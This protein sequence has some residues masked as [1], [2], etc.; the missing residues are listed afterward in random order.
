MKLVW[1]V[2]D[3]QVYSLCNAEGLMY[4]YFLKTTANLF[5]TFSFISILI[6]LPLNVYNSDFSSH[7]VFNSSLNNTIIN[8]TMNETS[9]HINVTEFA[10]KFL[11]RLTVKTSFDRSGTLVLVLFFSFVFT[12]LALYQIYR[13]GEKLHKINQ[14]NKVSYLYYISG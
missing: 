12:L 4:L 9:T 7:G 14:F 8:Q 3:L 6:I 10:K 2:T 13:Y 1:N 11:Q 5:R